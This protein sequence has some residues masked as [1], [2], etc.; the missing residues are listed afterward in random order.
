MGV[1]LANTEVVKVQIVVYIVLFLPIGEDGL[2]RR[3]GWARKT[4]L[5]A[6]FRKA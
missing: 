3:Y 4:H 6:D 1:I 2:G 5:F